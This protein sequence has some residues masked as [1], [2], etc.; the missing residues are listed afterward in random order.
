MNEADI[1][2]MLT[3]ATGVDAKKVASV[4]ERLL[5]DVRKLGGV[6]RSNSL[7]LD[8]DGVMGLETNK[9]MPLRS[10]TSAIVIDADGTFAFAPGVRQ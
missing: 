6:G 1:L 5:S 9:R 7:W 4:L 8:P 2:S 3:G 10:A